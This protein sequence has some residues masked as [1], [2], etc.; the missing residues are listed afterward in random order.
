MS[1]RDKI[2]GQR[3]SSASTDGGG[4]RLGWSAGGEMYRVE[5]GRSGKGDGAKKADERQGSREVG[6][7]RMGER[8]GATQAVCATHVESCVDQDGEQRI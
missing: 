5:E 8:R 3:E 6:E 2:G 1:K 4:D 7:A